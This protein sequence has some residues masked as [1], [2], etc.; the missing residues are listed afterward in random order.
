MV[1]NLIAK[2]RPH[3]LIGYVAID[4]KKLV[5]CLFFSRFIV[6]DSQVAFIL[7]PVAVSTNVQGNGIGQGLIAYGLEHLRSI[8]V[9]LAFTYGDP[10]FY[11]RTGFKQ[12]SESV[13]QAPYVLSQ[14]HGWLAQSLDGSPIKAMRGSTE[15]VEALREQKYW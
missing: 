5:G 13:V 2:T 1:S 15:C 7:S 14:P 11:S 8:G 4:N 9:N 12:I 3:D 6:P 10:A